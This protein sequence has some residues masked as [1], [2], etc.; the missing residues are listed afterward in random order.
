MNNV[1]LIDKIQNEVIENNDFDE[2]L[3]T[4]ENNNEDDDNLNLQLNFEKLNNINSDTVAW[5]TINGTN[6]NYPIVQTKDNNYY[7]KHSF[8][9]SLNSNGW[10]F[11]NYVNSPNFDDQNTIIFGHNTNRNTMFSQLKD[12]YNG[13]LGNDISIE[14]Y[15][16]DKAISYKVF[17]I[18]LTGEHDSTPLSN[19]LDDDTISNFI[20]NS[21]IDFKTNAS[22]DDHIL[23]LSTCYNTSEKK[24]ILNAKM[25]SE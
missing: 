17:S 25:V 11:L 2:S 9:K 7:L 8:D 16:K 12:I 19:Y 1:E 24:I 20:S 10:I 4:I 14:I 22:E 23:T 3:E 18:Y 15:L 6:I 13:K 21:K 5:I